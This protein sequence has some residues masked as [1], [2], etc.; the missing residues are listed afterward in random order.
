[1]YSLTDSPTYISATFI[2]TTLVTLLI[3]AWTIRNSASESIRKNYLTALSILTVWIIVQAILAAK[4]IY[5]TDTGNFPPRILLLGVLPA[6]LVIFILFI[7]RQG[8]NFIDS[9]PL[10]NL[11]CLHTVRVPVEVVLYWLFLQKSIPE[12]MTFEG[13]NFDIIAGI[14]APFI[15][16]YGLFKKGISLKLILLWNFAGLALLMNIVI[17]GLLSAPSPIQKLAFDQPNIAVLNFPFS[18]LPAFVVPVVLFAH[19]AS[20]RQLLKQN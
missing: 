16:Y 5:Y 20:I 6:V 18:L 8:R 13:R 7:T 9:L 10:A 19:L 12:L 11:T 4:G 15:A 14:T 17:H 2:L 1:M 3:L